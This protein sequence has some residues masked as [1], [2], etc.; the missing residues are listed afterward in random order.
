VGFL[1]GQFSIDNVNYQL[2][3]G[4]CCGCV[5]ANISIRS[6]QQALFFGGCGYKRGALGQQRSSL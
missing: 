5:A 1:I 2:V 3:Q 4:W 6:P